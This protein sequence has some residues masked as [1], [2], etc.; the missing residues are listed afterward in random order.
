[1]AE[2]CVNNDNLPSAPSTPSGITLLGRLP[3]KTLEA[4][5]ITLS[6]GLVLSVL[7]LISLSFLYPSQLSVVA[8]IIV[9][10][11]LALWHGRQALQERHKRVDDKHGDDDS[12][13]T[14]SG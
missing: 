8:G 1:M 5:A 6:V 11:L 7:E 14:I 4:V 13:T 12:G 9:P 2:K 3:E 10:L